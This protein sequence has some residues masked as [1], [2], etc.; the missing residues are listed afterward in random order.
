VIGAALGA[1]GKGGVLWSGR[2]AERVALLGLVAAAAIGAAAGAR[3]YFH[4][5]IQL[6]PPLALLAA[7]FYASLWS[8]KTRPDHWLLRPA[9]TYVWLALTVAGFSVSHW[10]GLAPQ[11]ATSETGR[12]LLEH[13]A[14]NDTIFVWGQAPRIYLEARRTPA[15]RY[16]VT[17][18]LTGYVFGW[19]AE[20]ISHIDTR[21]WIVPDAW[22]HLEEDFAKHPPV[23]VVDVQVPAKNAHYPVRDFPILAR[24]L[25][26]RYHPVARTAEGVIYR[27]NGARSG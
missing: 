24:L 10:L 1:L 19:S 27:V 16:V 13:S 25:A 8:G 20:S 15:C 22:K 7:P 11:R 2:Q 5:Y 18:P 3:F 26:E 17:F 21:E 6:I 23:Y 12:Y 4:Y 14:P 9:V